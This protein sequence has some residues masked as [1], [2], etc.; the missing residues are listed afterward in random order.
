MSALLLSEGYKE[1][2]KN[3]LKGLFYL[4]YKVARIHHIMSIL[5]L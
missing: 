4:Y 3:S 2:N 5:E 1:V